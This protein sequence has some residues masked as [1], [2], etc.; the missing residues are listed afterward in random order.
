MSDAAHLAT[1]IPNLVVLTGGKGQPERDYVQDV[2]GKGGYLDARIDG[3]QPRDGQIKLARAIDRGIRE[4]RHV[5]GEGPTGTG[6]SF[7]YSVPAAY[8][9]VHSGKRVC[10]VTANKNLQRQIYQKDL[11]A[12]AAA[13]P[14]PF[15]YAIRKGVASYLCR[16]NFEARTYQGLLFE[17]TEQRQMIEATVRWAET[18]TTGDYE[19]SPGPSAKVWA[20]FS[21][22]REE[23]DGR[24]CPQF[25]RCFVKKAKDAS[26]SAQ[27]IVTNYHLFFLHL[28]MGVERPILPEFDVVIMDEAHRAANIARE[29][30][31]QEITFGGLYRCVTNL[32]MVEVARFKAQGQRLREA[33]MKEV[34]GLWHALA[35]RAR[36]HNHVITEK[37]RLDTTALEERLEEIRLF[38]GEV[39]DALDPPDAII[40]SKGTAQ[41]AQ[42]S[43]YRK[44]AVKC[45]EKQEE[46]AEFRSLAGEGMVYFIEGSGHEP[47]G[48][49]VR[50]K[51]KA[52]EVSGFMR[53]MLF[54]RYKTVVQ[55]SATLAAR[56][57][58]GGDFAYLR[59]EMGMNPRAGAEDLSVEELVVESPFDWP[60]QAM[61][62][63]PSTM[64]EF[65]HGD[66][67]WDKA[68]LDHTQQ[69]VELMKGRTLCL[70]TSFRMLE[71]ARDRL[72]KETRYRILVQGEKT[73]R[74]LAAEFQDDVHSVLLGTESFA[75][76]VS[77]E[78]EACSCVLLDKIPFINKNDPVMMGLER[79]LK[80]RGSRDDVFRTYMLPEAIISFKQRVGRLIRTVEDVGVVVVLDRRLLTKPYRKQ[81]IKSIPPVR[82]TTDLEA[83]QPFLWE[84]G[85]V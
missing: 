26:E 40:S 50:L 73:N 45:L 44:L 85:V 14:W 1:K 49:Y 2:F 24:K 6:K 8:H 31:G 29:F 71:A 37:N 83:I 75:E 30:F 80:E 22:G 27:I 59:R 55:T 9:A 77:I 28:R 4:G 48:K 53:P 18:T 68:V 39:A 5:I 23:C 81:F 17:T 38:Y 32:H 25:G 72:R 11:A 60:Q 56:G 33:F 52:I 19:D 76:G 7:A 67:R 20:G 35:A 65:V 57:G 62:V 41:G 84:K 3:Y 12:L 16:R 78:G 43:A 21:T 10:I 63:I 42:A 54:E 47:Q 69:T 70:F 79:R 46:L 15:T 66:D 61:L 51:S 58:N 64:P 34:A 82:Q 74:E 13:V 36:A